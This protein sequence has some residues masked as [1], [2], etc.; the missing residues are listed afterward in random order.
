MSCVGPTRSEDSWER[1]STVMTCLVVI[2]L[3]LFQ[4]T[5]VAFI[6][7]RSSQNSTHLWLLSP[8]PYRFHG[9]ISPANAP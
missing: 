7:H 3:V 5:F 1:T 6:W 9:F 8:F 2:D 4:L